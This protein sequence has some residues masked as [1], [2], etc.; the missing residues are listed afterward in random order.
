MIIKLKTIP[1]CL[2]CILY[3]SCGY[4]I[5]NYETVPEF[6]HEGF[7]N[8]NI[9]QTLIVSQPE[10]DIT[11]HVNQRDSAYINAKK[12]LTDIVSG[13]L[14]K[15]CI[16]KKLT[17]LPVNT[18]ISEES[19]AKLKEKLQKYVEYGKIIFEYYNEN[20]SVV[21]GYRIKKNGL[22]FEIDSISFDIK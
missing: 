20:N 13:N 2:L 8:S 4:Q 12:N 14:A 7:I 15:Y 1:I 19:E 11:G 21:L 22:K 9:Y 17:S 18:K 5:K 10:K 3:L 16:N 6:Q